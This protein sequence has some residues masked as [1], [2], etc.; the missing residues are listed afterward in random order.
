MK[1]KPT[2]DKSRTQNGDTKKSKEI[3]NTGI[4]NTDILGLQEQE[5]ENTAQ[6]IHGNPLSPKPA[7]K[8][9]KNNLK[10]GKL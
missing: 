10:T 1:S 3:L 4:P 6:K 9:G 8:T 2:D 7:S 5:G